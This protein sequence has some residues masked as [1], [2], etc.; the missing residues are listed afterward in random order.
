[1]S[2]PSMEIRNQTHTVRS[3]AEGIVTITE[4]A[5]G[6]TVTLG[7][8]QGWELSQMIRKAA[9]FSGHHGPVVTL[10]HPFLLGY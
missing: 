1:M 5:T 9:S 4:H 6:A 7:A 2:E 3:D 10:T 8:G